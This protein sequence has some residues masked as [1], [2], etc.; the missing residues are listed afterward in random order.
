MNY[1]KGKYK[2]SIYEAESGYKV[3]LFRVLETDS[4]DTEVNKTITFTGYFPELTKDVSYIFYGEF[5]FHDRYGLQFQTESYEKATPDGKESIIEFLTSSF[6]KGCGLKTAESIYK[7]F[8]DQSLT[9]IKE[10]K[11]NLLLVSGMTE[12]KAKAIYDSVMM[13]YDVDQEII[14]LQNIGLTIKEAMK[15]ITLYGKSAMSIINDNPYLLIDIIDFKKI[16]QI[17]LL[18]NKEE[19]ERR[20]EACIIEAMKKLTFSS[21]DIYLDKIEMVEYLSRYF[22]IYISI[23]SI[24]EY[25]YINKK[26]IID[27][28]DYY[29]IDDYLNEVN[30]ASSI[31]KLVRQKEKKLTDFD[32]HLEQ[33]SKDLDITYN[34]EQINAIKTALTSG[35]SIITGGPGTGKT[36]I[37]NGIIKMYAYLNKLTPLGLDQKVMLLA[38]TGRASKKMSET[39]KMGAST[40]HRFLKWDKE[41]NT[42]NINEFN[43]VH[44]D[45]VIV[46]ETSMIDN[47]LLSSLFKGLELNTQIVFVG[48]EY[49]LPSVGPGLILNDMI[50]SLVVPHTRLNNIYRQS[51]NS[52]IP[53]LAKQIKETNI[54]SDLLE[55][56]DDYNFIEAPKSQIKSVISQILD[57]VIEKELSDNKLQVL[58]PMY[59]GENGIDNLNILLQKIFNPPSKL[60]AE[61][62]LFGIIYREGDKILNLVNDVESNIYNG[63]VG[64]IKEINPDSKTEILIID[65]EGN[66][67]SYKKDMISNITH[68]YAI[69]I[70]KSQ[71]SEFEH[72]IMP[73][74]FDYSRMLYNKLLYTG[75]S[76]AKKSL[77]LIGSTSAFNT[78]VNNNYSVIRKTSLK[79]KLMNNNII[80]G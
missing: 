35:I 60:K 54:T 70:H 51:E 13:Y 5:I 74:S 55:K 4:D 24:L 1:I 44:Y 72:V 8:G 23:D 10:N 2:S 29:L 67:V 17:F 26:I 57:K 19:D 63:D 9:T 21:G 48:D 11:D 68:A 27:N 76:R 28:E 46:D 66:K 49:Q 40:I 42:F 39:T 3:G 15:L 25:L 12:K 58:V 20:V 78:S 75:V 6:V 77:I 56:K 71:G 65:Y 14:S 36:T 32:K 34:E 37:I 69:S 18:S 33:V 47:Y 64:Y 73:I 61:L 43:K 7:K 30:N 31:N 50:N 45:L 22:K 52:F 80:I 62:T 53:V 41:N 38:P 79:K 59:K 16:D